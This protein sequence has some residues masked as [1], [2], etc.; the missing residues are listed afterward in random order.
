MPTKTKTTNSGRWR[1]K[2]EFKARIK[3]TTPEVKR[4]RGRPKKN[5]AIKKT[6]SVN[7]R[8]SKH[9]KDIKKLSQDHKKIHLEIKNSSFSSKK[10]KKTENK[11]SDRFALWL[12]IFSMLLFIFS[13]Y[14]TFYLNTSHVNNL[15]AKNINEEILIN[16]WDTVLI[17]DVSKEDVVV[18]DIQSNEWE[19]EI[20]A[21][22]EHT[23]QNVINTFYEKI[24]N[25]EFSKLPY[26][27]DNY[28]KFSSV[29]KTYYTENW[30]WNFLS[31]LSNEKIY[32]TNL[33][34]LEWVTDKPGVEYYAYNIKYKLKNNNEMFEEEW[35]VAVVDKNDQK[36]IWSIQCVNTWCSKM[37]FFNPQR[38][39]IK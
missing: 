9:N 24:N 2:K 7:T 6:D 12:L 14:K 30:M 27:V 33:E 32:I 37:P 34:K 19:D 3:N 4:G 8:I 10:I 23:E 17:K 38:Y 26:L 22:V 16:T 1:P 36:L 25:K 29:F 15:D 35:K 5:T 21:I 20:I 28:I 31:H 13:L 18:E 11:K 39:W